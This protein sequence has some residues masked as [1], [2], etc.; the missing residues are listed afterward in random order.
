MG[1]KVSAPTSG[2]IQTDDLA[3][4]LIGLTY[5]LLH[6][7]LDV[8]NEL[9][10][11]RPSASLPGGLLSRAGE[12]TDP[13]SQLRAVGRFQASRNREGCYNPARGRR[14]DR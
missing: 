14:R 5:T 12:P 7:H 2:E 6:D 3:D 1:Q 8:F 13:I 9:S 11:L 10:R 4:C